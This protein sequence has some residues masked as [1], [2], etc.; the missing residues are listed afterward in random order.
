MKQN[1]FYTEHE[2]TAPPLLPGKKP[3]LPPPVGKKPTKPD[4]PKPV[5]DGKPH[6][7]GGAKEEPSSHRDIHKDIPHTGEECGNIY[8]D[9]KGT[10]ICL[11]PQFSVTFLPAMHL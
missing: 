5:L 7:L 2:K 6:I 10:E 8:H 4:P 1:R 9:E 11:Y 3:V